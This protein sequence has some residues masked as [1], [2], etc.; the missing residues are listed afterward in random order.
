MARSGGAANWP[1]SSA[2][3]IRRPAPSGNTRSSQHSPAPHGLAE[4]KAGNV[5]FTG[6][7]TALIG[8]L[9]PATGIVTEYPMPDPNAKDPHTL[10]FDQ[11]GILWF[12]VQQANMVGRFR[13]GQRGHQASHLA[14]G[15]SHG[16]MG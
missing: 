11:S 6:N 15:R 4:D 8:K 13:S 3:S 16:P 2:G 12:T 7:N 14:D 10:N 9:D 5:W 1:A